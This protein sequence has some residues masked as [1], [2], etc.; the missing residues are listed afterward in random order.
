MSRKRRRHD[1]K[2]L[3]MKDNG[4]CKNGHPKTALCIR[5]QILITCGEMEVH[6]PFTSEVTGSIRSVNF[7]SGLEL[8]SN[9]KR[10]SRSAESR[11]FL[12]VLRFSPTKK[13]GSGL[14]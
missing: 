14:G 3:E 7:V 10:V 2:Y 11:E 5:T 6:L 1:N 4:N 13:V 9:G 12:R 8:T